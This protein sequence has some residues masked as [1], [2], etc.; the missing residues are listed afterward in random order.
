M[1]DKYEK[2]IFLEIRHYIENNKQE[3]RK[4]KINKKLLQTRFSTSTN[5]NRLEKN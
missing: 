5:R 2:L 3:L 4:D 1:K